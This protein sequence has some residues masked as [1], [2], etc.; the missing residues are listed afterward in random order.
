MK[1]ALMILAASLVATPTFAQEAP[2]APAPFEV[3]RLGDSAQSCEALVAEINALN[4]QFMAMQQSVMAVSQDMSRSAMS[5][6]RQRPGGGLASGLGGVAASFIPGAG[7]LMG[8]VQAVEQ[9]ASVASMRSQQDAMQTQ[10]QA[11]TESTAQMGP[12]SERV[13]HLSEIARSKSC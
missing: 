7:L 8:A 12:V 2:V 9:Q 5:A 1:R 4:Q 3:V 10:M 6:S 13:S 11:L